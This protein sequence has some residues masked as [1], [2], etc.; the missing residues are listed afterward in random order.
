MA[1]QRA[2]SSMVRPQPTHI[3]EAGSSIQILTHGLVVINDS[4]KHGPFDI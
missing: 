4:Q 3:P 2:I 1:A